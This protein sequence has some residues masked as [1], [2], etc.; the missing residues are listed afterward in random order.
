MCVQE[1]VN[2]IQVVQQYKHAFK[3]SKTFTPNRDIAVYEGRVEL[4][5]RAETAVAGRN[6]LLMNYTERFC[7]VMP[8]L[9]DYKAKTNVPI[10]QAATGYTSRNGDRFILI[11]NEA[12]WM[13][14]ME[15]SLINPNQ[16]RH[17]V[18]LVNDNPYD[19]PMTIE[20]V[21]ENQEF[22]AC[23]D[24]EGTN[25]FL[26][27]WT[28]TMKDLEQYKHIVLTSPHPWNPSTVQ[29]PGISEGDRE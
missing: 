14:L 9:E 26:E 24:S 5:S 15:V 29:F 25:I 10:V 21:G 4:D 11:F 6:C 22:I 7:D 16:L 27:T 20:T 8:Y 3:V 2:K 23:L 18:V 28:P 12:I 19:G 1:R 17:F 13:P